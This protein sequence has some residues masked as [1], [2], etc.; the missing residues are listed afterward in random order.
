MS[1]RTLASGVSASSG[2][3][4]STRL[5]QPLAPGAFSGRH[6]N[7]V[8]NLSGEMGSLLDSSAL[9]GRHQGLHWG[10]LTAPNLGPLLV[11]KIGSKGRLLVSK[12]PNQNKFLRPDGFI[13][14]A[15]AFDHSSLKPCLV[16]LFVNRHMI[17][18]STLRICAERFLCAWT[19]TFDGSEVGEKLNPEAVCFLLRSISKTQLIDYLLAGFVTDLDSCPWNSIE[20]RLNA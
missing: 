18:L 2:N 19:Y 14:G 10:K 17:L 3:C 5:F 9:Q 11:T 1:R 16:P 8:R 7:F 15:H 13:K 6:W 12:R 20:P 4:L